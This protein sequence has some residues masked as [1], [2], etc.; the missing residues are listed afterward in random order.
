MKRALR[1]RGPGTLG[2]AVVIL[3][4]L[5]VA[6]AHANRAG[7]HMGVAA[8]TR[9]AIVGSVATAVAAAPRLGRLLGPT[10]GAAR[11]L[12]AAPVVPCRS[13]LDGRAR[14]HP[15]VLQVFRR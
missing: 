7:D 13:R 14:G 6:S 9:L 15:A 3:L 12:T 4:V 10:P 2:L 1:R 11:T 8:A 5:A